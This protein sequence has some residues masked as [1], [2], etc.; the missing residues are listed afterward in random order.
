MPHEEEKRQAPPDEQRDEL[1]DA[2]AV[3][4]DPA[5]VAPVDTQNFGKRLSEILM[6]ALRRAHRKVRR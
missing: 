3:L 6:R 5:K 2:R 4:Q 1:A